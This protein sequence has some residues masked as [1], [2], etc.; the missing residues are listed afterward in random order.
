MDTKS[1]TDSKIIEEQYHEWKIKD[2]NALELE[3]FSDEY[4]VGG[5]KW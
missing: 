5:L 2:W 1:E 4:K 3:N